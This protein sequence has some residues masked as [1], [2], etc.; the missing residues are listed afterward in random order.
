MIPPNVL[1]LSVESEGRAFPLRFPVRRLINAG[2]V[3]RD[4]ATVQAHIDEMRH[5]GIPAPTSVPVFFMLTADNV[6][7]ADEIEV[8]GTNSSGEVEYVL[9]LLEDEIYVG[10]G[11]DHTDR[12]L[13]G[14]S[15]GKSKQVCKNVV[16]TR[17]WRYRDLKDGWDDLE[18]RSWVRGPETGEEILYQRGTL[19]T[20]LSADELV[21]LV[22]SRIKD[23]NG[24]GLVIFSGTV[25]MVSG[26]IIYSREFR[27][28]LLDPRSRRALCC[29]YRA[30]PLD[31]LEGAEE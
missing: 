2:Y 21:H 25:P 13:E 14:A 7:T 15:I 17:V 29:S 18:L 16:S 20:I 27:C 19:G 1:S 26:K 8:I 24:A 5:L 10:V 23:R 22:Q 12:T 6:T 9:L 3:G 4:R 30:T 28:E 31:Y 11:S